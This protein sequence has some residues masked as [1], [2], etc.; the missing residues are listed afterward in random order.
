MEE[1][2][3][4]EEQ[5][6]STTTTVSASKWQRED[7]KFP[8]NKDHVVHRLV[9]SHSIFL[10]GRYLLLLAGAVVAVHWLFPIS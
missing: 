4:E 8:C 5:A 9:C 6:L 3:E 10:S 7:T 1:E 2:E